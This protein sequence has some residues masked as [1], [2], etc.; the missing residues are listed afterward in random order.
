MTTSLA[1]EGGKPVRDSFL[2]FGKPC[3]GE[4]EEREVLDTLRSGWIGTGP[5]ATQFEKMFA[6][7]VH[8]GG[9]GAPGRTRAPRPS[10]CTAA[11]PWQ[12]TRARP[13]CT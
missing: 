1:I 7:Y 4:E 10:T 5:K 9:S 13:R 12:S 11:M 8:S 3:L 2:A 6:E